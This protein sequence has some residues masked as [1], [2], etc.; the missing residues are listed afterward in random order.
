[1]TAMAVKKKA[2]AKRQKPQ[3]QRFIEFAQK[4][5]ADDERALERAFGK[6]VPPVKPKRPD[7][8]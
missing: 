3:K 2:P 8:S 7:R 4:V 6:A 5:G 1:M